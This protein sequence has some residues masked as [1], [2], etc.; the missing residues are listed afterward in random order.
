M[1]T[2][3][4]PF[5]VFIKVAK[6]AMIECIREVTLNEHDWQPAVCRRHGDDG[7]N[8]RGTAVQC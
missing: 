6:E 8:M 4:M 7:R 1:Q 3:A 5:N 2:L